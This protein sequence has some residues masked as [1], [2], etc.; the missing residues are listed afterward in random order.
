MLLKCVTVRLLRPVT[1][2]KV[3]KIRPNLVP[4]HMLGNTSYHLLHAPP[5]KRGFNVPL[6][7]V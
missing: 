1:L 7:T 4:F 5:L 3:T 2:L 6:N